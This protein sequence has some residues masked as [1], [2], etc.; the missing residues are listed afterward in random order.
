MF[1]LVQGRPGWFDAAVL[2]PIQ[3]VYKGKRRGGVYEHCKVAAVLWTIYCRDRVM[4]IELS[5]QNYEFWIVAAD[6]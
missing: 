3:D 6:L 2:D 4:N 1:M 5:R